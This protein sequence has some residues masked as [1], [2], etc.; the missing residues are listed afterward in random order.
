MTPTDRLERAKAIVADYKENK[1]YVYR[2]AER[3]GVS[4]ETAAIYIA[5]DMDGLPL[6]KWNAM[7]D[8]ITR[9]S[10]IN[11]YFSADTPTLRATAAE[12]DVAVKQVSRI[13]RAEKLR[14]AAEGTA[15][16]MPVVPDHAG[17][18]NGAAGGTLPE[19]EPA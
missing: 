13:I 12:F 18:Q 14:R 8:S 10:I 1:A 5:R 11:F 19:G 15:T 4:R 6:L 7:I 16:K 17:N 2:I 3:H 9:Q